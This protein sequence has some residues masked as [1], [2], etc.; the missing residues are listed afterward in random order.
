M[1]S[2]FLQILLLQ[3]LNADKG[4]S[5]ISMPGFILYVAMEQCRNLQVFFFMSDLIKR[6]FK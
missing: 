5:E 6:I 4:G 1:E 2:H 3:H